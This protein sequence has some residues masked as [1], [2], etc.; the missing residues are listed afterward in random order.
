MHLQ[1][2][3]PR[4]DHVKVNPGESDRLRNEARVVGLKGL[5]LPTLRDVE[6]RRFRL[7]LLA[8]ILFFVVTA[9]MVAF[10]VFGAGGEGEVSVVPSPSVMVALLLAV[11]GFCLYA[12]EKELQLRRLT[13]HLLS[14][15]HLVL[16]LSNR[17]RELEAM[18]D[19]GRAVNAV[20]D[21][22]SVLS[23]I[24]EN[25]VQLLGAS[26]GS[27]MLL[28][29]TNLR[30]VSALG[31]DAALGAVAEVGEGVAGTVAQTLEPL[32]VR[33]RVTEGRDAPTRSAI[34]V[35]LIHRERL[36]GVLNLN[37]P[38][39]VEFDEYN[40]RAVSLF[41]EHAATAIANARLYEAQREHAEALAHRAFHDP[42]TDLANRSRFGEALDAL[43]ATGG[44]AVVLIDVDD[45]KEV[46][47]RFGHA[48]GDALLQAI[49]GRI[50]A[51]VR[52]GDLAARIGGDEFAI[53]LPTV[54]QAQA[55]AA[56]E[57]ILASLQHPFDGGTGAVQVRVSMGMAMAVPGVD[58][59]SLCRRAD[60]ALYAAKEAGKSRFEEFTDEIDAAHRARM[61]LD[62]ELR[63]A[64][65][66][67]ELEVHYQPVV[68]L[69][70]GAIRGAEALVRW[71]HPVRGMQFPDVFI[72]RAEATGMIHDLGRWVLNEAC[73]A[74]AS[75]P[76]PLTLNVNVSPIQVEAGELAAIVGEALRSSGLDATRLVLEVTEHAVLN[77]VL[78]GRRHLDAV[79]SLGVRLAIDD[80]GTGYSSLAQLRA[81]P[82][83][84]VK[85]DRMFV[86]SAGRSDADTAV[87]EVMEMLVQ[88]LG[89]DQVAE[90][91]ETEEQAERLARLGCP[92]GQ[93]WFW[94][95][96][97]PAADF[98]RL[99]G[100]QA[101]RP[102]Q[103]AQAS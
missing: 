8:L 86:Q 69:R 52:P 37:A 16:A 35:P 74:A 15:R 66:N 33:G 68:D 43:A 101:F 102:L 12:G 40:L 29:G 92:A 34:C 67:D 77:D 1:R 54:T 36:L 83:D 6:R 84:V 70:T 79:R 53:V 10:G 22:P 98:L 24:L 21:I 88:R 95:P 55:K 32:L 96:A 7:W 39:S 46:N 82:V 81:L 11:A 5:D 44:G 60:L 4:A 71:S 27:V 25:A 64:I 31:N 13:E 58:G 9:T 62:D 18:L 80:F 78:D 87:L 51:A 3:G 63:H 23:R 89:L 73:R 100:E 41:G 75:W 76:A 85:I 65:D 56:A 93:G 59:E 28:D 38:L 61:T 103:H 90:G 50:R 2:C 30:A 57:R 72:G 42:L 45:F 49:G 17:L 26:S 48:G 14:E 99:L 94:S 47:D 91:I 97:L 20:L 19:A